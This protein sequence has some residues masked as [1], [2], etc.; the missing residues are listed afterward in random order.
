MEETFL[1]HEESCAGMQ[2]QRQD[3]NHTSIQKVFTPAITLSLSMLVVVWFFF[4]L[5]FLMPVSKRPCH[6][7]INSNC[8]SSLIV[9]AF[10]SIVFQLSLLVNPLIVAPLRPSI[11][12]VRDLGKLSSAQNLKQSTITPSPKLYQE[13]N[14]S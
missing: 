9:C 5:K 12:S 1:L 10:Q 4:S 6:Y 3:L 7:Q 14:C 13:Q 11:K 8:N 2:G